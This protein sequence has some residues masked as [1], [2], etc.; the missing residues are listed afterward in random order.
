V[1]LLTLALLQRIDQAGLRYRHRRWRVGSRGSRIICSHGGRE[2]H[3]GLCLIE[4]WEDPLT[5]IDQ[6]GNLRDVLGV[7]LKY[8][9]ARLASETLIHIDGE[10][11]S[12]SVE[13]IG[14]DALRLRSN[15]GSRDLYLDLSFEGAVEGLRK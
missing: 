13:H 12:V 6:A 2:L 9:A 8:L 5:R 11:W 4:D 3:L 15:N 10:D 1:T 14:E 7:L